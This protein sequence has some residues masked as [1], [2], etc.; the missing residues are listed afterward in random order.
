MLMK[1]FKRSKE[2]YLFI[3]QEMLQYLNNYQSVR[4]MMYV[5]TLACLGLG[6]FSDFEDSIIIGEHFLF[7]LALA[8]IMPSFLVAVNFWKCV[9]VDSCYLR[10]F[11]EDDIPSVDTEQMEDIG[12]PEDAGLNFQWETR[13][14]RLFEENPEI[15]DKINIQ[16]IPYVVCAFCCIVLYWVKLL[17]SE[18]IVIEDIN[19]FE[20]TVTVD[21]NNIVSIVIGLA[22]TFACLRIF[23]RN[24]SLKPGTKEIMNGWEKVRKEEVVKLMGDQARS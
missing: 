20:V 13:H 15:D 8:V 14:K 4:N 9:V 6:I 16:H 3:R 19:S 22:V 2:E 10:V 21:C 1:K 11:Y 17:F 18:M 12:D 24:W 7:L 23:I 5:S